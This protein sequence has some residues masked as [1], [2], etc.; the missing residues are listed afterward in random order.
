MRPLGLGD[1]AFNS[2]IIDLLVMVSTLSFGIEIGIGTPG[3]C[4]DCA[5][6]GESVELL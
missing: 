5:M 4:E 1:G 6:G 2:Y 3:D